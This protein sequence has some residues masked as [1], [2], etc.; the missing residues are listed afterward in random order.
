[1]GWLISI[2]R[3]IPEK[4]YDELRLASWYASWGGLQWITELVE[5]NK[6]IQHTNFGY[7]NRYSA[8]AKD[9]LPFV[10]NELDEKISSVWSIDIYHENIKDCLPDEELSIEAC[11]MS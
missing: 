1:M 3:Q 10:E 5:Q 8:L 4:D 6:A 7:P 11:D 2:Q 9:I